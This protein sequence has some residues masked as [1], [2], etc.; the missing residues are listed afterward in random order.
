VVIVFSFFSSRS[1]DTIHKADG[2]VIIAKV[3]E[4]NLH[5]I[6]YKKFDMQDG[7]DFVEARSGIKS[8][9]YSNGTLES[10]E[11]DQPLKRT[12]VIAQDKPTEKLKLQ[13]VGKRYKYGDLYLKETKM[14][15]F[16]LQ[17][18]DPQLIKAVRKAKSSKWKKYISFGAIPCAADAIGSFLA[19]QLYSDPTFIAYN[20]NAAQSALIEGYAATG[21][22]M[23][24]G[25]AGMSF[26]V[27]HK[28]HNKKVVDLYNSLP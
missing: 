16:V 26:N 6:R 5:E 20:P 8:I 13:Q 10:F 3:T 4:V 1:Q 18:N 11:F 19:Y 12:E 23:I 17:Q 14:Y 7:P 24:C 27:I 15:R 25:A 21:L 22:A 2:S 28:K 9:R